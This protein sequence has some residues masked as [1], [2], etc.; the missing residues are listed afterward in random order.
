MRLSGGPGGLSAGPFSASLGTTLAIGATE[1]IAIVLDKQI[2]DGPWHAL[3]T[4]RSGL[5]QRTAR[6]TITFPATGAPSSPYLIIAGL[7]ILLLMGILIALHMCRRHKQPPP[8][9]LSTLL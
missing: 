1:P 7:V 9:E 2:P 5:L 3:V 6:A 8:E 4:L